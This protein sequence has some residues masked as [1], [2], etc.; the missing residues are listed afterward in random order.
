LV[1]IN[2]AD[3]VDGYRWAKFCR[4]A[5]FP[6]VYVSQQASDFGWPGDDKLDLNRDGHLG[7]LRSYFV[8]HDTLRTTT[9]Q[10]GQDLPNA[11]VVRNPFNVNPA[12]QPDWPSTEGGMR[13]ALPAR[14]TVDNKGHDILFRTLRAEKWKQ[15]ALQV[16]LYGR[17]DNAEGLKR[18]KAYFG[19]EKVHFCGQTSD[20]NAIWQQNHAL[21]LPS[22][23]EGLPLVLVEAM[24]MGRTAIVTPTA[25]CP[26]VVDDG[27]TG[28]IA[29][30]VDSIHLDRALERAWQARQQWDAMGQLARS[31]IQ[32]LVPDKPAHVFAGKVE[33]LLAELPMPEGQ[34]AIP[35]N[36]THLDV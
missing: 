29:E 33:Q 28:F 5:R 34:R 7:A 17:G 10:I 22:R 12:Q 6:Y 36:P 15:R 11:E 35:T 14:L 24:M 31:R 27:K 32:E 30:A 26:E 2:Q 9:E 25:G 16:N 20:V 4:D 3:N 18:L 21:V 8:S 1:I 19:L 23:K 13:L